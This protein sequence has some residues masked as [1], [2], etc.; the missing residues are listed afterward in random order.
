MTTYYKSIDNKLHYWKTWN[1]DP[2]T[3][4]VHWGKVGS[5]GQTKEVKSSFFKS[6]TS[7]IRKE[8]EQQCTNGYA[9]FDEAYYKPLEI[10]Y[11]IE[12]FGTEQDL[13]KRHRLEEKLDLIMFWTGLG[14][15]NG[16]SIGS[17]TMEVGCSVVD[18]EIAKK[19]LVMHLKNTEFDNYT[20]IFD[21]S[22]K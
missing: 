16:G 10:E 11:K 3:A 17:G 20:R 19:T 5:K 13:D 7:K 18:F 14:H 22:V 8:F 12:G 1:K 6:H 15:T 21:R 4:M 9:A 2:K